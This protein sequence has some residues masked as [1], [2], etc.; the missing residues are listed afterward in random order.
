MARRIGQWMRAASMLLGLLLCDPLS[1]RDEIAVIVAKD[2]ADVTI[3]RVRLRDIY[4]KK[5]LLDADGTALIPINLPPE[6]PLRRSL[7]ETLFNK[8]AQQLQDYWNQRYFHGITPPYVLHS[9]EAVVQFVAKTPGAIGYIAA[10]RLDNRVKQVLKLNV[11][12]AQREALA[13]V[14]RTP[15][16][17]SR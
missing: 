11:S 3:D 14:C 15:Q 5:I 12:A 10:C 17:S 4:L 13:A 6:H 8:S 7:A 9:Q 16:D 1:A 2:S